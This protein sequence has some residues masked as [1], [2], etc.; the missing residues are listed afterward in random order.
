M[1]DRTSEA[2]AGG[3]QLKHSIIHAHE[4]LLC[5]YPFPS[6]TADSSRA[7]SVMIY[8]DCGLL[9]AQTFYFLTLKGVGLHAGHLFASHNIFQ[10]SIVSSAPARIPYSS[11]VNLGSGRISA[12]AALNVHSES[13]FVPFLLGLWQSM[14]TAEICCPPSSTIAICSKSAFYCTNFCIL[15]EIHIASLVQ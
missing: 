3:L 1:D 15:C 4:H 12:S 9:G 14:T 13:H 5:A 10:S 2:F 6:A 8:A 7:F 11:M